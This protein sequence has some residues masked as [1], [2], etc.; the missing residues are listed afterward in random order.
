VERGADINND[1]LNG[2]NVLS[3]AC[4]W[5]NFQIVK[6]LIENGADPDTVYKFKSHPRIYRPEIVNYIENQKLLKTLK[7]I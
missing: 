1:F 4:A 5:G 2:G 6:Y 3:V 7:E